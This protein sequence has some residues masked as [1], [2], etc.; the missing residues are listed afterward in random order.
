M[1]QKRKPVKIVLGQ[2]IVRK[3]EG[4]IT[5]IDTRFEVGDTYTQ[6]EFLVA[7][8]WLGIGFPSP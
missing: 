8:S 7:L 3:L 6:R 2:I 4:A 1:K 5:A